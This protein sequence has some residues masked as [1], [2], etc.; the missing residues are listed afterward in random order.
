MR[1]KVS[2][3]FLPYQSVDCPFSLPQLK[4]PLRRPVQK[5]NLFLSASPSLGV[6]SLIPMGLVLVRMPAVLLD[7]HN[8]K[9]WNISIFKR[10]I[11]VCFQSIFINILWHLKLFNLCHQGSKSDL[12]FYQNNILYY[13]KPV[14]LYDLNLWQSVIIFCYRFYTEFPLHILLFQLYKL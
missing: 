11:E 3:S 5:A 2:Y 13:L 10:F 12:H 6:Q 1:S 14:F 9:N 8:D 7:Q 4:P